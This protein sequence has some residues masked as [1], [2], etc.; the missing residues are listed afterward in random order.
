[1]LCVVVSG[2][3]LKEFTAIIMSVLNISESDI[4]NTDILL[5]YIA[6]HIDVSC[7]DANSD[8]WMC[9][10]EAMVHILQN[11]KAHKDYKCKKLNSL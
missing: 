7:Y 5:W 3:T 4:F 10:N 2:T 8:K 11:A 9:G 6:E 1:M